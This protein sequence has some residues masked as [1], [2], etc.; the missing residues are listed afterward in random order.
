MAYQV[1][2][3]DNWWEYAAIELEWLNPARDLDPEAHATEVL[4]DAQALGATVLAYCV[5]CGGYPIYPSRLAPQ[6]RLLRGYDLLG[7]LVQGAHERGLKF[8]GGVLGLHVNPYLT[9][10]YPDWVQL[11]YAGNPSECFSFKLL[12]PNS[13]YRDYL[14]QWLEELLSRYPIDGIYLEGLYMPPGFCYCPNCRER[15]QAEY[16]IELPEDISDPHLADLY[17]EFRQRSVVGLVAQTYRTMQRVSPQALLAHCAYFPEASGVRA[18]APHSDIVVLERQ[19]GFQLNMSGIRDLT[20][21]GLHLRLV[22]GQGGKPIG[23]SQHVHKHVD[24]NYGARPAPHVRLAYM[25]LV[26]HGATPQLHLQT[27]Y[28]TDRSQMEVARQLFADVRQLSP[29]LKGTRHLAEV[30]LLDCTKPVRQTAPLPDNLRGWAAAFVEGHWLY[31]TLPIERLGDDLPSELQT[32]VVS[33]AGELPVSAWQALE[34]FCQQGGGVVLT[35]RCG[36][37][38]ASQAFDTQPQLHELTGIER[39][40]GRGVPEHGPTLVWVPK[41]GGWYTRVATDDK[42]FFNCADRL[43]SYRGQAVE[44]EPGDSEVLVQRLGL[45]ISRHSR[46]N[47]VQGWYPGPPTWPLIIGRCLGSGRV[48][49]IGGDLE[50]S[51]YRYGDQDALQLL[52]AAVAWAHNKEPIIDTDLPGS[53]EITCRFQPGTNVLTLFM[54]NVTC[55]QYR[56]DY[57][58]RFVVPIK[59]AM[60]KLRLGANIRSVKTLTGAPVETVDEGESLTVRLLE[61]REYEVVLIKMDSPPD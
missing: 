17:H 47:T 19:W 22:T 8:V 31:D 61:L 46:D 51:F 6:C 32:I 11:D 12:C 54:L 20:E 37:S 23:A 25:E 4:D 27:V 43:L 14:S 10:E 26:M 18:L 55:N 30:A 35:H 50:T 56:G 42:S 2:K 53:V 34:Q 5:D 41:P 45:D 24:S 39:V 52:L 38:K 49:Y 44:F 36:M 28:Q 60:V 13:P 16:G 7:A 15:F 21:T 58:V 1:S 9:E 33:D 3:A 48:V 57:V 59:D 40:L 29:D